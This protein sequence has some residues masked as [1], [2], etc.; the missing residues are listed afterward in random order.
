MDEQKL[1]EVVCLIKFIILLDNEGKLVYSKYYN[2]FTQKEQREFEKKICFTC[3]NINVSKDEIDIFSLNDYNIISKINKEIAVFL[4][5]GEED[6]ECL[7]HNFY[8]T[9]ENVL[10]NLVSEKLSKQK[11]LMNFENLVAL[12]DEMIN[13]GIIMET[14]GENLEQRINPSG[15][16]ITNANNFMSFG[17]PSTSSSSS[18]GSLFGALFSG[19]KTIFG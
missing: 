3:Q 5:I 17:S 6:N 15:K 11:I 2:G 16:N 4:G 12:I 19:A 9:F 1:N 7:G 13:E 10:I 14:D 18:G 8:K